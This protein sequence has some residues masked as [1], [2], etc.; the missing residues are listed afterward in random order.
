MNKIKS[1]TLAL[2]CLLSIGFG[3]LAPMQSTAY[4]YVNVPVSTNNKTIKTI[5]VLANTNYYTVNTAVLNVR[6]T[7]NTKYAP[8]RQL[9]KG[10]KVKV[11]KTNG[12]WALIETIHK[13]NNHYES[14]NYKTKTGEMWVHKSYLKKGTTPIYL[15]PYKES[16]FICLG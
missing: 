8:V 6:I 11:I 5:Q 12:D 13:H 9:T 10:T 3:S 14:R 15:I 1:K 4:S 7:P 16:K 2:L